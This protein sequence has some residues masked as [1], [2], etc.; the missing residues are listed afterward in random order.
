MK[1]EPTGE[2]MIVEQYHSTAVDHL[3]Y[4]MHV[5]SYEFAE[6]YTRG[7]Q[8]LDYG[9]GSGYGSAKIAATAARVTAVDVASDAIEYAR[10]K[11][12]RNNLEFACVPVEPKLPFP[13]ASFDVV[14]SF[15]VFEHVRN[16]DH[17]LAEI[18]RVLSPRGVLVLITPDRTTRLLPMQ[19]PWNRWHIR[20]Y[21]PRTLATRLSRH[22]SSVEVLGMSA[23]PDVISLELRRYRRLKWVTLPATLPYMPDRARVMLLN[24]LH[25]LRSQPHK[26]SVQQ[27]YGFDTSDIEISKAASPSINVVAI[28][29]V[30]EST[31]STTV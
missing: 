25:K 7:K 19:R 10:T 15:Q 24:V 5:A 6:Q 13:D 4:L 21:N 28:C 20:E 1:L 22:F 2:R 18:R 23:R 30:A 31:A 27:A 17:Y 8:V 16:T 9:C 11:F 12:A 29:S 14:L 3:I 26:A